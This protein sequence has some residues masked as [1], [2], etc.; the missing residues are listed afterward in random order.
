[1]RHSGRLPVV[2]V[3]GLHSEARREVVDGLL[4]TVPGSVALHHDLSSAAEGTVRRLVRDA[5]GE[6]SRAQTPLVDDCACCALREDL[7]PELER[8]PAADRSGWRSS[9]CGTRWNPGRWPR[10]SSRTAG[11]SSNSPTW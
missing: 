10:S 7:V 3:A 5:A 2:I 11:N 1:M 9:S 6:L 8:W 4:R